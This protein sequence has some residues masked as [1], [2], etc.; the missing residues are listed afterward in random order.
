LHITI[1]SDSD[2]SVTPIPSCLPD[3]VAFDSAQCVIGDG[4]V[5][6]GP[7]VIKPNARKVRKIQDGKVIVGFAGERCA[8]LYL[9]SEEW[10]H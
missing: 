2:L 7:T 9:F 6:M 1:I 4:Q 10:W 5:S 3:T 8:L